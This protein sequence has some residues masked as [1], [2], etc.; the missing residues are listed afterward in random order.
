MHNTDA[1]KNLA[2]NFER[3]TAF[4]NEFI[5]E[6]LSL[7]GNPGIHFGATGIWYAVSHNNQD[8]LSR[9]RAWTMM[10]ALSITGLT[11]ISLKA[12]RNNNTPNG[13]RWAWPSGHTASSFTAAAVLDEFYGPEIGI[14]AYALASLVGYRMMDSGDHWA[15]DVLFGATL[16]WV[17]GHSIA[18]EHKEIEIAGFEAMPYTMSNSGP[19]IGV[20][21]VKRF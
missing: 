21:F 6:A 8:H 3:H 14:P 18:G 1:D 16:G 10:K 7:T 11:T 20:N 13:K 17:V 4:K 5:D 2:A 9:N 12:I 19:V 15:S